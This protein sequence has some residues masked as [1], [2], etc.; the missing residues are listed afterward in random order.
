MNE[1]SPEVLLRNGRADEAIVVLQ[2]SLAQN[3]NDAESH[4]LLCRVY[5]GLGKL[6]QASKDC[7]AA[8]QLA[9][10]NASYHLWLGRAYGQR[11]EKANPFAAIG[12][13]KKTRE[14][15]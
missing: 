11:A 10:Q 1:T 13:A 5:L 6:D 2:K 8:V 12:L 9:P 4:N 15:F 7:E 3:N 14:E